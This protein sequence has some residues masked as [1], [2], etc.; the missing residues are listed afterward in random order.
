MVGRTLAADA[1]VLAAFAAGLD[2]HGEERLD[3]RIAFVE[4]RGDEA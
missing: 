2:G 3:G 1:D 4:G